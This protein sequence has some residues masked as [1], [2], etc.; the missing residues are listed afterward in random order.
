MSPVFTQF[1][2]CTWQIMQQYPDAFEFN[3]T[4]LITIH[5]EL[6][7]SRFGTFLC[8]CDKEREAEMVGDS[9][10]SLWSLILM[11]IDDYDAEQE[12]WMNTRSSLNNINKNNNNSSSSSSGNNNNNNNNVKPRTVTVGSG[13][14]DDIDIGDSNIGMRG[15][16]GIHT[17]IQYIT[18][19]YILQYKTILYK[20]SSIQALI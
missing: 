9:T 11:A 14:L 5:N 13:E 2:D 19:Q 10:L 6:Y 18:L 4:F 17:Y 3:D 7:A 1:L 8:N 16:I 15:N 20:S 12:Q